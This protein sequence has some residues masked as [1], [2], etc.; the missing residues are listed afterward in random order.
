MAL[1]KD[2]RIS[3]GA[4]CDCDA[5]NAS[6]LHHSPN[7][8]RSKKVAAAEDRARTDM[9]FH[10]SEEVPVGWTDIPLLDPYTQRAKIAETRISAEERALI[11][12]GNILRLMGLAA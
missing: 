2:E 8:R 1:T 11:M 7:R 10:T 9:L 3:D 4:P 12:G 5:V 6:F